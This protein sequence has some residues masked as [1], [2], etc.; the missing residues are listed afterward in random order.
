[1]TREENALIYF[2]DLREQKLKDYSVVFDTAPK[3]SV[4]YRAVSAEIEIY[5][6]AI[7]ALEQEPSVSENPNNCEM[8]DATLEERESIDKYIKSISKPT[9]VKFGALEQEPS[10]DCISRQ[11]VLENAFKIY[12]HE[13]GLLEVVGVATIKTL[14]SIKPQTGHWI[15]ITNGGAMKQIYL[16]SVCHRQIEDDG[17]EALITIKYPYC[18]C[19]ARMESED[20]E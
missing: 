5:D 14:P 20:K 13:V 9:G 18:H 16:C 4:V 6:M 19:G 11:A 7:K 8:R 15:R 2:K 17:I 10:G 3:D 12:T 1:M